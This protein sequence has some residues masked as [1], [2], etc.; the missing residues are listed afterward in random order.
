MDDNE[1]SIHLLKEITNGSRHAFDSFYQLYSSFVYNIAFHIVRDTGEAEDITQDVFIE[2]L[3]K[4]KQ[5]KATKGS[6]KAWIAVKTKS[7]AID[8]LRKKQPLLINRLEGLL[9]MEE[10]GADLQFLIELEQ[11]LVRSALEKIPLEQREVIIRSYFQGET[12]QQIAAIMDKP[13]GSI[14]SLIRYGLN[15]LRKQK[16]LVHWI[17]SSGGEKKNEIS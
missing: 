4:S 8:R 17:E 10:K 11:H 6:V 2:I 15:N 5:Y 7:R 3:Q 9:T 12:H 16:T 14:K 1:R 13:L